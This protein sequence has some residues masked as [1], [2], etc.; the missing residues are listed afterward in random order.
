MTSCALSMILF[1][2]SLS[3]VVAATP[4]TAAEKS[5]RALAVSLAALLM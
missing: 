3:V 1:W 4:L 5:L 2:T